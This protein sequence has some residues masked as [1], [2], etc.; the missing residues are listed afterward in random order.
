MDVEAKSGFE[1]RRRRYSMRRGGE[2]RRIEIGR[3]IG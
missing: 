2:E 1:M 3:E